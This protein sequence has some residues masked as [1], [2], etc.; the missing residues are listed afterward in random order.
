[1]ARIVIIA[2]TVAL[3]CIARIYVEP[4]WRSI[5][6]PNFVRKLVDRL[7][8]FSFGLW[9]SVW[10]CSGQVHWIYP[11]WPD[12]PR[13]SFGMGHRLGICTPLSH[14]DQIVWYALPTHG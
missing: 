6:L 2:G 13:E 4:N 9:L 14:Y 1:M 5:A 8:F 11:V 7:I 10:Q 3:E 12:P